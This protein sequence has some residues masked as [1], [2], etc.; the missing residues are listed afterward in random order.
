MM[1]KR[2]ER[3]GG[4]C[5]RG[6]VLFAALSALVPAA[7]CSQEQ[8]AP[9]ALVGA[10]IYPAPDAAPIFDGAIVVAEGKVV[11]V[12]P[13]DA[14]QIP[15]GAK[16]LDCKGL[17]ITAGFQNSHVHFIE[18]KWIDAAHQPP[19]KLTAQLQEMLTRYGFTTVVD[20]ASLLDNTVAL[21]RRIESGEVMGPRILTAGAGL[22]PPNG[23]PYYVKENLPAEFIAAMPQP[24]TAQ[25]AAEAVQ[26]NVKGGADLT[27]LFTGSWVERGKVLPMPEETATA[28]AAETHRHHKLVFTHPSSVAGLEVALRA[29]VDVLAHALDDL[30][31]LT[32]E[33][34]R[35]RKA[36]D[37]ALIPT[38]NLWGGDQ[39]L[40]EIL[41]E[42]HDY[43]RLGG[44]ILFGTDVG[45]LPDYDPVTEY[46][47]MQSAGLGWREILASLTTAPAARFGE[48][49]RRG[50][51]APGM[52]ADLVVLG[53]DPVTDVRAFTKVRH[54]VRAGRVIYSSS[55]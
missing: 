4:R 50:R 13:R 55:R 18:D 6:L 2:S 24:S 8:E 26:R 37:M 51:I 25:Q 48:A 52:D 23:I 28:A 36:Q 29:Q 46:V 38:L 21:R 20:A 5:L 17:V 1:R 22:F 14:V 16:T 3:S 41:D 11:S 10:R 44:T 19:A 49:S 27:K 31:G 39:G 15:A 34:L 33:H 7:V 40:F 30:Q 53:A 47:L 12:G 35:R 43:A 9:L 42:V 32:P 54:A 45:Y